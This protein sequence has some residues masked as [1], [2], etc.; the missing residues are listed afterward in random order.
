MPYREASGYQQPTSQR[1]DGNCLGLRSE[2]FHLPELAFGVEAESVTVF[3]N[4]VAI[5]YELKLVECA[6]KGA[7][8]AVYGVGGIECPFCFLFADTV[9]FAEEHFEEA[10]SA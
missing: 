2:T 6:V 8:P 4:C 1:T 3:H 9:F 7:V 10:A 5:E